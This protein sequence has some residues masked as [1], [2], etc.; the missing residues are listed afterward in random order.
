VPGS[1]AHAGGESAPSRIVT[2]KRDLGRRNGS[3][4]IHVD[5]EPPVDAEEVAGSSRP[6]RAAIVISM[7]KR[8][9]GRVHRDV[10]VIGLD[11][12]T[13]APAAGT[14]PRSR[15]NRRVR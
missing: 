5:D 4:V 3:D 10:V 8:S 6:S 12:L 7:S 11:V 2:S 1:A 14:A 9:P 13:D 15:T